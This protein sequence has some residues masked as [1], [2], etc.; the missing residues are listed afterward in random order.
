M[1]IIIKKKKSIGLTS[2]I[3]Y[4][5]CAMMMMMTLTLC[6]FFSNTLSMLLAF[7]ALAISAALCAAYPVFCD[8][9][10]PSSPASL[11]SPAVHYG[12]CYQFCMFSFACV[13]Q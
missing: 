3:L 11:A 13:R 2:N 6:F 9:L 10:P 4:D 12:T 5:Y 1:D 8:L 7:L